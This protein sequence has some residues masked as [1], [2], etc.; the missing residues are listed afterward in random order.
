ME[1]S[2]AKGWLGLWRLEARKSWGEAGTVSTCENLEIGT[3]GMPSAEELSAKAPGDWLPA[4]V[5]PAAV[6]GPVWASS[7]T[8]GASQ[9]RLEIARSF[10]KHL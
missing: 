2:A 4:T 9:T 6:A 10:I 3:I 8:A 5:A 7:K 1:D